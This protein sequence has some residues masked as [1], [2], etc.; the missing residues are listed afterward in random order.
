MFEEP[1]R[2][3]NMFYLRAANKSIRRL[4]Y[5]DF[6]SIKVDKGFDKSTKFSQQMVNSVDQVFN[7]PNCTEFCVVTS[8]H[9]IKNFTT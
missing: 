2:I 8:N 6:S 5:K 9:S 4:K 1:F 3:Y 7:T